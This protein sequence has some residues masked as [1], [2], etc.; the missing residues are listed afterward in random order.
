MD[1]NLS[2][3]RGEDRH[4]AR[5]KAEIFLRKNGI[6]PQRVVKCRLSHEMQIRHVAQQDAGKGVWSNLAP[7]P[8]TDGLI[9]SEKE[10]FLYLITAD[11]LPILLYDP[12]QKVVGIAHAGWRGTVNGIA[13]KMVQKMISNFNSD[14]QHINLL[15]GPSICGSCYE[16]GEE[17][18]TAFQK[19]Y[20]SY[21]DQILKPITNH[22]FLCDLQSAITLQIVESG[23]PLI[24]I[25]KTEI[26]TKEE[27]DRYFSARAEGIETGRFASV[28]GMIE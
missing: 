14:P 20:P 28:I 9:T 6:A 5:Q 16:V 23:I 12:I 15:I 24:Q 26:C 7:I 3:F 2:T 8:E 25:V 21:F 1:G 13:E 22:K 18:A 19:N 17:V 10:L 27:T 4:L 11:C